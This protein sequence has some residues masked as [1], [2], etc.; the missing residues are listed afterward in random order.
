MNDE[1]VDNDGD[2]QSD[3]D[4]KEGPDSTQPSQRQTSLAPG[5]LGWA[6]KLHCG[7]SVLAG[8]GHH[9]T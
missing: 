5:R 2:L 3:F 8:T 7:A 6:G 1:S 9:R 4:R